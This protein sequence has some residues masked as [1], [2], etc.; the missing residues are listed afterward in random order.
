M[1]LDKKCPRAD[2]PAFARATSILLTSILLICGSGAP[3]NGSSSNDSDDRPKIDLKSGS[4]TGNISAGE[5]QQFEITLTQ[6][7]LLRLSLEKGDLA[8]RLTIADAAGHRLMDKVSRR[9]EIMYVSLIVSATGTYHVEI[10]SL[11]TKEQRNYR[12]EV[13]PVRKA[14]KAELE[15][16]TAEQLV[17]LANWALEEWTERSLLQ[18]IENF[19]RAANIAV[20]R[21]MRF[22]ARA[23]NEAGRTLFL[24]GQYREALKR[25][26]RAA[27]C[28]QKAGDKLEYAGA[29]G[30]MARLHSYL[31]NNLEAEKSLAKARDLLKEVGAE[32]GPSRP[33]QIYAETL[34]NLGEIEYSKG[35]LVKADADFKHSLQ[36][37]SEVGDRKG[38]ARVH[39]FKGYIA[40]NIGESKKAVSEIS[41]A[42]AMYQA[43]GD[44]S[45]EASSLTALGLSHSLDRDEE[46]AMRLHR[47][48]IEIFRTIG[49]K[50]SQAIAT[51]A[52]G[53][54]Y[55]Y[56]NDYSMALENYQK[57]LS[58]LG[59]NPAGDFAAVFPFK[60]ARMQRLL[61]NL[62]QALKSYEL[63]LQ[64]SRAAGKRRTE[65]MA[66]N[67]VARIYAS[68]HN[69]E[70]TIKQYRK[71]LNF[72]ARMSDRRGQATTLNNLGDFLFSLREKREAL[73][74]YK[75][76][77]ALIE[78]VGDKDILTSILY[79]LARASRD[80][81]SL[82][83]ALA[84][85]ERSVRI[86]EE[87]RTNVA[88]PDFRTSFFAGVRQHYELM[89]NILM[90]C[91]TAWPGRGYSAKGFLASEN[92]RARSLIDMRAEVGADIRAGV[93]PALLERERE[94]QGLLRSQ[95]EYQMDLA[96]QKA[97]ATNLASVAK[98]IDDLQN[99][100]LQIEAQIRD[101]N[102]RFL[103]L[104]QAA[105][106]TLQQVQTEL[107][108]D[109]SVLLEYALGDERSYLWVISTTSF[110][111]YEL[112]P[113]A[114]VEAAAVDVYKSLTAR[115]L[116]GEV[117]TDYQANVEAADASYF[118]KSLRL[119][120]I[121]VGPA[122]AQIG[123]KRLLVVADGVLQYIPLDALPVPPGEGIG[124]A[125]TL[126][127]LPLL[128]A[129][130]E[131]VML[132]SLSTVAAIR[133][134]KIKSNG[135]NKIVAVLADP[136]F[137]NKDDRMQSSNTER[138]IASVSNDPPTAATLRDGQAT[139]VDGAPSRL[140]HAAEEASAIVAV[141]PRGSC[142]L[143]QGFDATRET[144]MSSLLAQYRIVHF[145]A[146]G[147]VNKDRPELSGIILSMVDRSGNKTNGFVPLRDIY[148]LN[149]SADLVVLSACD[150][151]L[152]KDVKGEG[153]VGLT[154]GFIA[155]GSKSVI[156]S[157]WKVD[158]RATSVL[159]AD[160]YRSMLQDGMSPAAALRSAKERIRREKA[161]QAPYF[162]AGFVLQ[163]DY[164]ERIVVERRSRLSP[165]VV[166]LLISALIV[167]GVTILNRHRRRLM[168]PAT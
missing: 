104:Q 135:G 67:D 132:P 155:S 149:L 117:N 145:A 86:I 110:S 164:V 33:K 65:A 151:A 100:Y 46:H 148:N 54:A 48:A 95:A 79:N 129:T 89:I 20:P 92:G 113:R 55:E 99:E 22:A 34:S 146:H 108:D 159:M 91:E 119:S 18:A 31:G 44:K 139:S 40:G 69:R 66:L 101:Q 1:A 12:L 25:F 109:D 154:H 134:E 128:I 111:S 47:Q 57:A 124:A 115:Q 61:G 7:Q 157:L 71:I 78:L 123:T 98:Q 87:L 82:E 147:L 120:R 37:L 80:L 2:D 160:L 26:T 14:S 153:L 85:I 77:L 36:L 6:N 70:K 106:L 84:Y 81:G 116:V 131:V 103:A 144:A 43:M 27:E 13:D 142:F 102:P 161:W 49:D 39:L 16:S 28:A 9:Y 150:T 64:L 5:V 58:L 29:L 105:P 138:A 141:A 163:G 23:W 121:L 15:L 137:S 24:L 62:D 126:N 73:T 114:T 21:D 52:F 17:A 76:A 4:T 38:E 53:Q 118:D 133:K 19:D 68:Q 30:Q 50:H 45:G 125:G 72:Y 166:I 56:L 90:Q 8:A 59:E 112:P 168:R 97:D 60:I 165:G 32:D 152:G 162:W 140:T 35:N 83:D 74:L 167:L 93:S 42:L 75:R 10:S 130:H 11:E 96:Q 156:A 88:T 3:V 158:D 143:A 122:L 127:D 94:L 41:Q 107:L 136:V 63:C 51:N